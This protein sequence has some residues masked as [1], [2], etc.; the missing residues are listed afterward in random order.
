[1]SSFD[2]LSLAN[3]GASSEELVGRLQ[4]INCPQ[5][6]CKLQFLPGITFSVPGHGPAIMVESIY[7]HVCGN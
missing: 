7:S 1:M 6:L 3:Q 5:Y 4:P 2:L